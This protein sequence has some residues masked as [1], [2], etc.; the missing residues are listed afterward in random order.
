M[1]SLA[2]NRGETHKVFQGGS[3]GETILISSICSCRSSTLDQ[4]GGDGDFDFDL[5]HMPK[6]TI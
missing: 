3:Q 5:G 4:W 1:F 6:I 2:L